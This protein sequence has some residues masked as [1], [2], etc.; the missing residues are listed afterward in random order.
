MNATKATNSA[1]KYISE[2]AELAKKSYKCLEGDDIDR[3]YIFKL[4][5]FSK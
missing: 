3:I 4:I 2:C 1:S 5:L